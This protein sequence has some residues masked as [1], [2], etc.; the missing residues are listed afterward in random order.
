MPKVITS[1]QLKKFIFLLDKRF[2]AL[3]AVQIAIW[4]AAFLAVAN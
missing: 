3:T 4:T 1:A 2:F